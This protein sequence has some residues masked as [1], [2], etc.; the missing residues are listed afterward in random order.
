MKQ[1]HPSSERGLGSLTPLVATA[2]TS[3]CNLFRRGKVTLDSAK[4][5]SSAPPA[6]RSLSRRISI[7]QLLSAAHD[8]SAA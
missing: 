7:R 8:D 5:T 2:A 4:A 6:S 3:D 1:K